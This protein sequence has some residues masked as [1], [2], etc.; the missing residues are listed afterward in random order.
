MRCPF[1]VWRPLPE[2]ATA[3]RI[4]PRI[5]ILHTAVA[6]VPSLYGFFANIHETLESTFFVA[7]N[8]V[9]EQYMDTE[10]QAD[11]N[12]DAND[13]AISVENQDNAANPIHPMT[14][15]QLEANIRLFRWCSDVHPKIKRQRC[16]KWNGSGYGYHTMWGAPSHWTPYV[17]TCPAPSRIKQ[18]EEIMIPALVTPSFE[19]DDEMLSGYDKSPEDVA[20]ATIRELCDVHWGKHAMSVEEQSALLKLWKDQGREAMMVKL[21]DDA[22]NKA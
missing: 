14:P 16:D 18:F 5:V 20:R 13:F 22:Q 6:N 8:G 10:R 17:K 15:E 1:A 3:D 19:E 9:I 7:S 21:L 11:A 12:R 4:D 2:N